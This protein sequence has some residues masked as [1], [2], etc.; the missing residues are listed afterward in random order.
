M[1]TGIY[2]MEPSVMQDIP[3]NKVFHMPDLLNKLL[4]EKRRVGAYP[5]TEKSWQD[6]GEISEMHKMIEAIR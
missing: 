4:I 3:A 5:I 2:V 6:M 1:N